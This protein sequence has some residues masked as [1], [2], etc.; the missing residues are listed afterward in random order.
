[1]RWVRVRAEFPRYAAGGPPPTFDITSDDDGV[2]NVEVATRPELLVTPMS[3]NPPVFFSSTAGSPADG[4]DGVDVPIRDGRGVYELPAATWAAF[5]PHTQELWF[6]VVASTQPTGAPVFAS[7][8]D[9]DCRRG[10]AGRLDILPM[11]S[12]GPVDPIVIDPRALDAMPAAQR[13]LVRAIVDTPRLTDHRLLAEV[14]AHEVFTDATVAQQAG[15]LDLFART[16]TPGRDLVEK[17]LDRRVQLASNSTEPALFVRDQRNEGTTLDHLL[18]LHEARFHRR[19][20]CRRA[21]I[22]FE[23]M[24]ELVDPGLEINQGNV[25]TCTVTSVQAYTAERN[26]AELAR[27][28]RHLFDARSLHQC[29]LAREGT[30]RLNPRAFSQTSWNN[31]FFE[32]SYSERVLQAALMDYGNFRQRYDP[33][34]DEFT[35]W[36]NHV[37]QGGLWYFEITRIVES[38]FSQPFAWDFGGGSASNPVG[39]AATDRIF[40]HFSGGGLPVILVTRWGTGAHAVI[41]LRTDG[42]RLIFRNPQY[43]GEQPT[44][45][46][47]TA[48]SNP[49]RLVHA[50][51]R[52]EESIRKADLATWMIGF[53]HESGRTSDFGYPAAEIPS[54]LQA[55]V[56]PTA[57]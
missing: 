5:T 54:H 1:M 25:G 16:N 2:A 40:T 8:G 49:P 15:I 29:R 38:A 35:D 34:K 46:T 10:L 27:W 4:V 39:A 24:R 3:S 12:A 41:G 43:R 11:S 37:A 14:T 6:R 32:R 17:L 13:R 9:E 26:P 30:L 19:V 21:H 56:Q 7:H 23:V 28:L 51:N 55:T 44:A 33:A 36:T 57:A 52:A 48:L 18:A 31:P 47:G 45:A 50:A 53:C 20:R 42:D 22:V